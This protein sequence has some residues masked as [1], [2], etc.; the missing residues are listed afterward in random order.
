MKFYEKLK[1]VVV[2]ITVILGVAAILILAFTLNPGGLVAMV[3]LLVIVG[4]CMTLGS[5][6]LTLID[7]KIDKIKHGDDKKDDNNKKN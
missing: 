4:T 6:A 1:V 2:I 7:E 5:T 3:L